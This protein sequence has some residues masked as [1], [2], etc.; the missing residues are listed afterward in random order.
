[1]EM[2]ESVP[3]AQQSTPT[4]ISELLQP[5]T[6]VCEKCNK[7][8]GVSAARVIAN[9][10]RLWH[11]E[12]LMCYNCRIPLR[13]GWFHERC[14]AIFCLTCYN[15]MFRQRCAECYRPLKNDG[16]QIKAMDV[17]YHQ[18]C[19][20]C[21]ICRIILNKHVSL[22]HYKTKNFWLLSHNNCVLFVRLLFQYS[23][24]NKHPT[25]FECYKNQPN[26]EANPTDLLMLRYSSQDNNVITARHTN[27]ELDEYLI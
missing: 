16:T 3:N 22:K 7:P 15:S 19:F 2:V 27:G 26:S 10:F 5:T 14:K 12:C 17:T 13:S 20:R 18:K 11:P 6:V 24:C 4:P 9:G 25:C 8:L 1:M 21:H 23:V